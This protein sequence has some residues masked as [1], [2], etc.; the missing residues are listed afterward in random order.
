MQVLSSKPSE[1]VVIGHGSGQQGQAE[2]RV[3]VSDDAETASSA[4]LVIVK[5]LSSGQRF[6]LDEKETIIGRAPEVDI[7]LESPFVSRQHARIVPEEGAYYV[8]DLGSKN[9]TFVNGKRIAGRVLLGESDRLQIGPYE[10]ALRV[11]LPSNPMEPAQV[12]RQRH[13]NVVQD[14]LDKLL[15]GLG[16]RLSHRERFWGQ[17]LSVM[18]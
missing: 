15:E 18:G 13:V 3:S 1:Q 4:I 10:M 6:P 9:G 8:E 16:A 7:Y 14:P 12:N 5:G 11:D 17:I 2:G